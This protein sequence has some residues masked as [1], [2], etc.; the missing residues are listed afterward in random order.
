MNFKF[1]TNE[2]EMN[3]TFFKV[4]MDATILIVQM[5]DYRSLAATF[6]IN[7]W[8]RKLPELLWNE[9]VA[10]PGLDTGECGVEDALCCCCSCER[11]LERELCMPQFVARTFFKQYYNSYEPC[12]GGVAND[13]RYLYFLSIHY[14][15]LEMFAS[16]MDVTYYN[17]EELLSWS[18]AV[19]C[20]LIGC[21]AECRGADIG[22]VPVATAEPSRRLFHSIFTLSAMRII[23]FH[24]PDAILGVMFISTFLANP[25]HASLI[26][27]VLEEGYCNMT[28]KGMWMQMYESNEDTRVR[29]GR[30]RPVKRW[31][32]TVDLQANLAVGILGHHKLKKFFF[33]RVCWNILRNGDKA[34]CKLF[35]RTF[36]HD[37]MA[38]FSSVID[39]ILSTIP[40][41]PQNK[42][43]MRILLDLYHEYFEAEKEEEEIQLDE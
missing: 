18:R 11:L 39:D 6:S 37:S 14:D 32:M 16:I 43:R 34:V 35:I 31:K 7:R 36:I 10:L 19:M 20:M 8:F 25:E 21:D 5:M 2:I 30:P 4:G 33:T 24:L 26:I 1:P 12:G 23:M 13:D 9:R 29:L 3:S 22:E 38:E 28:K 27:P 15:D 41:E 42:P 17:D 40:H